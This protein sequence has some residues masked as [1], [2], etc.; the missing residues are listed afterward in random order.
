M[1]KEEYNALEKL[2]AEDGFARDMARG[3]TTGEICDL[4]RLRD[5]DPWQDGRYGNSDIGDG[6]LFADFYRESARFVSE[7]KCWYVFDGRAWREDPGALK[8]MELCKRLAMLLR[9]L[10]AEVSDI[11]WQDACMKRALRWHSR[12]KRETVLKD[13]SGVHCLGMADFDRDPYLF[14]CLNGTLDLKTRQFRAHRPGD[15]LTMLSGVA[16]DPGADSARWAQFVQEVMGAAETGDL[17][18]DADAA[19]DAWEK[20]V[21]LQKAL[22]YALTGDTRYECL[23]ILHGATTR[24]GKGT[25][26]ETFLRLMGDYGRTA[27]PESIGARFQLNSSGPN[28]D[29]ARL[30]GA[31]FVN[32]SEPDR[33]L[34]L[35]A[36]LVK[37]LTGNDTITARY[38]HENSFEYRPR[39]KM[40]INTN[41]L[42]QVTDLTLFLSGRVKTI[43]FNRHFDIQEQDRGLKDLFARPEQLS[44]ILNWC[45]EGLEM[46]EKEGMDEPE[47]VRAATKNYARSNDK[48]S[49]FMEECLERAP[50]ERTRTSDIYRRYQGWC[51]ENGFCPENTTNFRALLAGRAEIGKKKPSHGGE[52]TT[53]LIGYRIREESPQ[54]C[55]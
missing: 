9:L 15:L 6:F 11:S 52:R 12:R 24:N 39:F 23:F 36:S 47:A 33:K 31:R 14:N 35:S 27:R 51:Q 20:G 54:A 53:V 21:Y 19:A 22:G 13:A 5:M 45:L 7:R 37:T 34:V 38:L 4:N 29:V 8:A 28:E 32:I 2:L 16:Y 43:P 49:L 10:A 50:G 42:P 3:L 30:N 44:G 46:L 48:M 25:A 1:Q 55:P 26:M 18:T 41:Y 17:V 40:F